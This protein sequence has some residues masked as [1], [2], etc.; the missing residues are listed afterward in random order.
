[1][2]SNYRE[3]IGYLLPAG[4]LEFF[5]LIRVVKDSEGLSIY[6]EEKNITPD[7][8]KDV[9][10]HS[11]G[12]SPEIRIRDFPIREYKVSLCLKHRRWENPT[13]G[14]IVTRN[15]DLVLSGARITKE[16][17]LFLKEAFR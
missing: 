7:E 8:Y 6:L 11:K 5:D 9:T 2:E 10:L 12:F 4:T 16:F 1:M 15:W 3:L 13:T 14:E 17:G